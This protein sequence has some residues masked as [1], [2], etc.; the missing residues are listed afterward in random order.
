MYFALAMSVL[1]TSAVMFAAT[2]FTS[3]LVLS[4]AADQGPP[5]HGSTGAVSSAQQAELP[6]ATFDGVPASTR[7]WATVNDPVMGGGSVSTFEQR[8]AVG[9]WEGEVKVVPFLHAPGFCTL[10]TTDDKVFPDCSNTSYMTLKLTTGSGLPTADFTM[11][12]GVR[13]VST[14][15]SVYEASL[16]DQYC[17]GNDCRVPWSAF[18]LKWRGR[19]VKGPPLLENLDKIDRVGLGTAGT[20]GKFSLSISAITAGSGTVSN[21]RCAASPATP[22]AQRVGFSTTDAATQTDKCY[23]T[24]ANDNECQ[25]SGCGFCYPAPHSCC[26]AGVTTPLECDKEIIL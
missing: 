20:A 21:A 13:G 24:C 10:R 17:C 1:V 23:R 15:G 3:S 26:S 12:V 8:G 22:S 19:P 5:G 9:V 11:Q 6:L 7:A 4:H 14:D 25:A 16:S 18:V 2:L